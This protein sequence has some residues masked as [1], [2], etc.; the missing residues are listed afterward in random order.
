MEIDEEVTYE[1]INEYESHLRVRL[2]HDIKGFRSVTSLSDTIV[3]DAASNISR[4]I[5]L[6]Y[7]HMRFTVKTIYQQYTSL[8][9][10]Y[11]TQKGAHDAMKL[12]K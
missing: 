9:T 11:L 6:V 7:N 3:L 10:Y 8:W 2:D 4:N 12:G 1:Y 5:K